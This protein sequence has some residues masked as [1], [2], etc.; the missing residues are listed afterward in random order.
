[1]GLRPRNRARGATA[2][3]A[4][5][6]TP[7]VMVVDGMRPSREWTCEQVLR[8]GGRPV[9]FE[10]VRDVL[11][12]AAALRPALILLEQHQPGLSGEEVC[13]RLKADPLT[14][15]IPVAL[16]TRAG[17]PYE[18][19]SC[20]RAGADEV[21]ARADTRSPLEVRLAAVLATFGRT[22]APV[23]LPRLLLV[24]EGALLSAGLAAALA[25]EGFAV[26]TALSAEE[27]RARL[28]AGHGWVGCVVDV[29]RASAHALALAHD[30]REH[31]VHGGIPL[32]LLTGPALEG[33]AEARAR[34][35]A[36]GPLL[37]R[38]GASLAGLV[39]D[40][41]AQLC[42]DRVPLGAAGRAPFFAVAELAHAGGTHASFCEASSAD[43]LFL[44]TCAPLPAGTPVR[45]RLSLPGRAAPLTAQG[46]VAWSHAPR[47]QPP[48]GSPP[49]GMAV[50]LTDVPEAL[51][52]HL[53]G[54]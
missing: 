4:A 44:R 20:W 24:A 36:S 18:V 32:I 51:R 37:P 31:P 52:P 22:A 10:H 47:G 45:L 48:E 40:V 14:Q 5:P 50:R 12:Q 46:V 39:R 33:E 3:P 7:L 42:P 8:L 1:M 9:A 13:R 21:L 54:G 28:V 30:V 38:E 27:A 35:L 34:A 43:A 41:L 6:G 23:P 15:H 19:M 16:V 53:R 2:A 25:H 17:T 49:P 29:S 26:T 11:V